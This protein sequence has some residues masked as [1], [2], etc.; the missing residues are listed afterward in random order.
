MS[1]IGNDERFDE[2]IHWMKDASVGKSIS[3]SEFEEVVDFL[4]ENLITEERIMREYN[5][6]VKTGVENEQTRIKKLI[7]EKAAEKFIEGKD[8]DARKIRDLVKYL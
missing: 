6:G 8:E 3:A 2:L 7:L 5:C 4:N 1:L